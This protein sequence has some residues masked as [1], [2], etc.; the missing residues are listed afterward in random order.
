VF[1]YPRQAPA[2]Y[3][4]FNGA[5]QCRLNHAWLLTV[6]GNNLLDAQYE[7]LARYRMPGRNWLFG[8]QYSF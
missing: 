6:K 8:A 2:S 1:L 5:L 3:W 4:I 7:E